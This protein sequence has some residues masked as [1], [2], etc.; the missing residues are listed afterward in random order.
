[1]DALGQPERGGN[2]LSLTGDL[3]AT[4]L[5]ELAQHLPAALRVVHDQDADVAAT[6]SLGEHRRDDGHCERRRRYRV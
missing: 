1:L 2:S 6:R 5:E 3:I 4:P